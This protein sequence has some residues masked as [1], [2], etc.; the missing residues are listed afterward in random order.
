VNELLTL[1]DNPEVP[2]K[3]L[4]VTRDPATGKYLGSYVPPVVGVYSLKCSL[5]GGEL[6]KKRGIG[7]LTCSRQ[8]D[9]QG[10]SLVLV[11]HG[12]TPDKAQRLVKQICEFSDFKIIEKCFDFVLSMHTAFTQQPENKKL[13]RLPVKF[14]SL[15][16]SLQVVKGGMEFLFSV[17]GFKQSKLQLFGT[18]DQMLA[19]L[20]ERSG[21]S[22]STP[23]EQLIASPNLP[24]GSI[25]F[26]REEPSTYSMAALANLLSALNRVL[27][28]RP[29][30]GDLQT[31]ADVDVY[32]L[33]FSMSD[34][35][36]RV[37]CNTVYAACRSGMLPFNI[38]LFLFT[39]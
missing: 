33:A 27:L 29:K 21:S 31:E 4:A 39:D 34:A 5:L 30:K 28:R 26:I 11:T 2:S 25:L 18:R 3:R 14:P 8:F 6:R 22:D 24:E 20:Q 1:L 32:Q 16:E 38:P 37:S 19:K 12:P 15:V 23:A 35:V 36:V 17:I 7:N 9:C 13:W 10:R